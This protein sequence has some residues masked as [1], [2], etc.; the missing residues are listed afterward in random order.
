MPPTG[1][2]KREPSKHSPS[3]SSSARRTRRHR[4]RARS[5]EA[6]VLRGATAIWMSVWRCV[7]SDNF[8]QDYSHFRMSSAIS[9]QQ[10]ALSRSSF[11]RRVDRTTGI[12]GK[13]C[14][15]AFAACIIISLAN[16]SRFH[17]THKKQSERGIHWSRTPSSLSILC[18]QQN[19]RI[20]SHSTKSD[21]QYTNGAAP[22]VVGCALGGRRRRLC[23]PPALHP[24]QGLPS[25]SCGQPRDRRRD[26]CVRFHLMSCVRG[27]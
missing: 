11:D 1:W 17:P 26:G 12:K 7:V 18:L 27:S 4:L 6:A 23:P 9:C 16:I 10:A 25:S 8:P 21:T 5:T 20:L 19:R 15:L 2:Q 13:A 3:H 14:V 24:P 22:G